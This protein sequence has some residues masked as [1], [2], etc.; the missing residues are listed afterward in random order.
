MTGH[1]LIYIHCLSLRLFL[2]RHGVKSNL[3]CVATCFE[4]KEENNLQ[5]MPLYLACAE[6]RSEDRTP[7]RKS[8]AAYS[9]HIIYWALTDSV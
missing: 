2:G 9:H 4:S 5:W 1:F 6:N 3:D 8:P 7:L